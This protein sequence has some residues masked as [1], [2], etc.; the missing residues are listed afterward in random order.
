MRVLEA[1]PAQR[2]SEEL[3]PKSICDGHHLAQHGGDYKRKLLPLKLKG[4]KLPSLRCNVLTPP[5]TH[6]KPAEK[7]Y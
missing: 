3:K 6:T 1:M 4:L 5:H 2:T 7:T